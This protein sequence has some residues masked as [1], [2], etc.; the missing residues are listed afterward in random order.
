[1]VDE[2]GVYFWGTELAFG[3]GGGVLF[4]DCLFVP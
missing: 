3:R 1:M 4:L 2:R